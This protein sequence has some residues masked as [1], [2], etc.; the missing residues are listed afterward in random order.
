M[1]CYAIT[2]LETSTWQC[3]AGVG[4]RS[5]VHAHKQTSFQ[6][7]LDFYALHKQAPEP[8]RITVH[9]CLEFY[10][11]YKYEAYQFSTF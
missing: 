5:S 11:E 4:G 2:D 7:Q 3:A 9:Y 8:L 1:V 6:L 10:T